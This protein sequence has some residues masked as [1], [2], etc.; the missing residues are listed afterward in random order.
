MAAQNG[1]HFDGEISFTDVHDAI[2]TKV[3]NTTW[4]CEFVPT[5]GDS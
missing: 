4:F 2:Q 3:G 5:V 1:E